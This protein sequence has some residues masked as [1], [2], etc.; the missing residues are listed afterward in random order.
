MEDAIVCRKLE[1]Y[2]V[3]RFVV[4][5]GTYLLVALCHMTLER[6]HAMPRLELQGLAFRN[7]HV[8]ARMRVRTTTTTE[9]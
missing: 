8:E 3:S 4:G 9:L 2:L 6:K 7:I 1:G 5:G